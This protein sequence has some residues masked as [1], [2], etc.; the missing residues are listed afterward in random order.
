MNQK[1]RLGCCKRIID[2]STL[3]FGMRAFIAGRIPVA[4]SRIGLVV[5]WQMFN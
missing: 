4:L 1:K 5:Y 3:K 2:F